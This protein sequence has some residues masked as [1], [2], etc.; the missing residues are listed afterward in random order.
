MSIVL[1]VNDSPHKNDNT[2]TALKIIEREVC[3]NGIETSWFQLE[4]KL[5]IGCIACAVLCWV[6][7]FMPLQILDSFLQVR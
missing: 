6:V 4:G 3:M 7:H 2:A 5:V 1:L